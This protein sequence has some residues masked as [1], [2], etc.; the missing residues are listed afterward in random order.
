MQ[1]HDPSFASSW[2]MLT[3]DKGW[4]KP[5]L[6][7]TLVGWIPILGQIAVLGYAL[8]WARLTAWGVEAAPKQHGVDYGKVLSTGGRAFLVTLSLGFVAA[9]VMNIVFPGSFLM[10]VDGFSYFDIL[11]DGAEASLG[12]FMLIVYWVVMLLSETFIA[13]ATLRAT[14]YDSF[15]AGWRLDRL[16][17]MVTRDF[18]GFLK[19]Y[20][21]SL[22]GAAISFV[23]NFVVSALLGIFVA[24][25]IFGAIGF[26]GMS[27]AIGEEEQIIRSLLSWGAAPALLLVVLAIALGFIG[28]VIST[29]MNLVSINAVGQWFARFDV[30]RWGVS[31]APLPSDVPHKGTDWQGA[32]PSAPNAPNTSNVASS[33]M[34]SSGTPGYGAVDP[35]PAP[36]TPAAPV[37]PVVPVAP[38]AEAT[39]TSPTVAPNPVAPGD[40]VEVAPLSVV[41]AAPA[42]PEP[43]LV[44]ASDDVEASG[45][46]VIELM[47]PVAPAR[48]PVASEPVGAVETVKAEVLESEAVAPV[49][50]EAI[51][52]D[53]D[54]APAKPEP[55]PFKE[56]IALGPITS[57]DDT[58]EEN[59][60]IA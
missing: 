56:P 39:P 32:A 42:H 52:S 43:E 30:S 34:P 27:G 33:N 49:E 5:L 10:A 48:E 41:D 13:A 57:D 31:A 16:F 18:S 21:V 47:P 38:V 1:T 17:Q 60:P 26:V 9:I 25:G 6:V 15:S 19:T 55:E 37:A 8:E 35:D 46:T 3:R 29:G 24:G 22:I 44:D 51:A 50:A 36:T 53:S 20:L 2:R 45:A 4:I 23:Y 54:A 58:S 7:L 11:T 12:G 59:G 28:G 40:P 14:L